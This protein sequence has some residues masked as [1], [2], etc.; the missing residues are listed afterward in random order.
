PDLG[1]VKLESKS[2]SDRIQSLQVT[3]TN[4]PYGNT[5]VYGGRNEPQP[6]QQISE[7]ICVYDRPNYEGRSQCWSEGERITDLARTGNWRN[8]I[9]SIRVFG[10]TTAVVYQDAEF[11]GANF[12]VDRSIPDLARVSSAGLRNW[13]HQISSLSL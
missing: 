8:R 11:R 4:A 7:G 6:N 3:T 10:R 13:D 2:W 12:V 5:S 1:Q 9:S